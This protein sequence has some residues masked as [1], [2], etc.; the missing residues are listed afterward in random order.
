MFVEQRS[1]TAAI[2]IS[3]NY[4]RKNFY[5]SN[6]DN[7]YLINY[8]ITITD[9]STGSLSNAEDESYNWKYSPNVNYFYKCRLK[10]IELTLISDIKPL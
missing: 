4:T 7:I 5:T 9:N 8:L 6:L 10:C 1:E 3:N 2:F